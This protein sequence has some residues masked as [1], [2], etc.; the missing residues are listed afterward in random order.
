MHESAC[1]LF[2]LKYAFCSGKQ[3]SQSDLEIDTLHTPMVLVY[4]KIYN[5]IFLL[6][7]FPNY[8]V[9]SR[10]APSITAA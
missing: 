1:A 8:L 5:R 2:L 6:N 4:I 7:M 10:G 9:I 3:V